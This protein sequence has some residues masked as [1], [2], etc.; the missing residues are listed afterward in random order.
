V[1]WLRTLKAKVECLEDRTAC[2]FISDMSSSF[3]LVLPSSK[4][5]V[6]IVCF[7]IDNQDGNFAATANKQLTVVDQRVCRL[8]G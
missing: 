1:P 3:C 2:K 7:L 4:A 8:R 6:A 5:C